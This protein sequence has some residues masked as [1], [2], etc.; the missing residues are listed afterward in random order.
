[1]CTLT[2]H[3]GTG[4]IYQALKACKLANQN[5]FIQSDKRYF[6]NI[7][8]TFLA[9][10]M[11]LVGSSFHQPKCLLQSILTTRGGES[12]TPSGFIRQ[13]LFSFI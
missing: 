8:Q 12:R 10:F 11:Q 3:R 1:M 4:G 9:K 13:L 7:F 2:L 6:L 5:R